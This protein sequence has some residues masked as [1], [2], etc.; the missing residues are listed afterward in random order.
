MNKQK[1]VCLWIIPSETGLTAVLRVVRL[2][3]L[4]SRMSWK[5][6]TASLEF[7]SRD[8]SR[9]AAKMWRKAVVAPLQ[10][11][12]V[13][14]HFVAAQA[15]SLPDHLGRRPTL[16]RHSMA[17]RLLHHLSRRST[18]GTPKRCGGGPLRCIGWWW[19]P[20]SDFLRSPPIVP[21]WLPPMLSLH[22]WTLLHSSSS[23]FCLLTSI[24]YASGARRAHRREIRTSRVHF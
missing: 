12:H 3:K 22:S 1:I 17:W 14:R 7:L 19:V 11:P 9:G 24:F 15:L 10:W 18:T 6:L 8:A 2:V 16:W 4:C 23:Y 20:D 5:L 13:G 21:P